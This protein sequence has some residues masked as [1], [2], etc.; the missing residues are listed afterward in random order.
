[1]ATEIA[2]TT[3]LSDDLIAK[4]RY[5]LDDPYP[6][7]VWSNDELTGW[8]NAAQNTI[9]NYIPGT[10]AVADECFELIKGARQKLPTGASRL[11]R[12]IGNVANAERGTVGTPPVADGTLAATPIRLADFKDMETNIPNWRGTA[13]SAGMGFKYYMYDFDDP[14]QFWLYPAALGA[15]DTNSKPEFVSLIYSQAPKAVDWRDTGEIGGNGRRILK[16]TNGDGVEIADGEDPRK[17]TAS[18]SDA[19][20]TIIPI[21]EVQLAIPTVYENAI[22]DYILFRAWEKPPHTPDR[23]RLSAMREQSFLVAVQGARQQDVETDPANDRIE[24]RGP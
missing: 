21:G 20:A 10:T 15:T 3:L 13:R 19:A 16:A 23:Q 14:T 22:I 4:C 2:D 17:A 7:I 5:I 18:E 6:G 24:G 8:M 11:L 12:V 1:M 9:A